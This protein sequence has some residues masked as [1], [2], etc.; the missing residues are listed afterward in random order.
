[1]KQAVIAFCVAISFSSVVNAQTPANACKQ[2]ER[3]IWW[4]TTKQKV[5]A[6]CASKDLSAK[7]GYMQ[8][9][10]IKKGVTE[11]SVPS[12]LTHPRGIFSSSLLA[13]GADVSFRNGN[14]NYTISESVT[15]DTSIGVDKNNTSLANVSC[16]DSSGTLT[17]TETL[18]FFND[19][20]IGE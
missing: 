12:S 5:F 16:N 14:I 9:R 10:A 20:G 19:I 7:S 17:S 2:S 8:Y 3:T 1:M 4:C 15:G 11:L 13:R 6:L 18:S